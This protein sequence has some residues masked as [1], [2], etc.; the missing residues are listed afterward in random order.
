[1]SLSLIHNIIG[2]G[3]P[4]FINATTTQ[5]I[6][7]YS[8]GPYRYL[9]ACTPTFGNVGVLFFRSLRSRI[10]FCVLYP[11]LK[12]AAPPLWQR[13]HCHSSTAHS[14]GCCE[15]LMSG[16][17]SVATRAAPR[18]LR[19]GYKTRFAT[20]AS[21]KKYPHVSKCGVQASKYR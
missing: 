17:V 6:S 4:M 19:W 10:L 16:S 8:I 9:L 15:L 12:S 14:Y 5:Q 3:P 1:M 7:I 2:L 13:T 20:G 21:E 18:I 11:T